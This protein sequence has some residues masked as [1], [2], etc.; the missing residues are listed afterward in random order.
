MAANPYIKVKDSKVLISKHLIKSRNDRGRIP[1]LHWD[2]Y[3]RCFSA[4]VS[5]AVI[6]AVNKEFRAAL[7]MPAR[8]N[9]KV[10]FPYKTEPFHHQKEALAAGFGLPAFAY[11]L[12]P[13]LGKSKVLIDEAQILASRGMLDTVLIVCPK[14]GKGVW[15]TSDELGNWA[16]QIP[17]HGYHDQWSVDVW[18]GVSH[19]NGNSLRW[20]ITNKDALVKATRV[21]ESRQ[22]SDGYK[23]AEA[24]LLSGGNTMLVIDES[25]D[26]ANH[27]S[28][29][30]EAVMRLR[31]LS[32]YRRI[33]TGTFIAD[34]PIDLYSQLYFLDPS[35]V[36][37][38]SFYAFRS[39]FCVMGGYKNKQI[40]AYQNLDELTAM[41][42]SIS[43]K[44]RK[45][46][47]LDLPPKTY[48]VRVIE[49][50]ER[51]KR[52]YNELV[53][54]IG[55][56]ADEH[57][58]TAEMAIT[59]AVKLRQITGGAVLDDEG[60]VVVLGDEKLDETLRLLEQMGRAKCLIWCE[61]THEID[62]L[63]KTIADAGYKVERYDGTI[64]S[65]V[66]RDQ[67]VQRFETGDTQVLVLQNEAGY[68]TLTLNQAEYVII[69]SNS[70][71]LKVRT[72]LEDRCH[73]IGQG[74]NVTYF[75]LIVRGSVDEVVLGSIA[76]KE[77]LA[78][79]VMRDTI[80]PDDPTIRRVIRGKMFRVLP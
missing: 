75:D 71:K 3:Y 57:P 62:R 78:A 5:E 7:T 8:A 33:L 60:N 61:F 28:H 18:R 68:R 43:Y 47:C 48:E 10:V 14:S 29:R 58:I 51:T 39:H 50:S 2:K 36:Y 12:D 55:V 64:N 20:G 76:A 67:I 79:F 41:V 19:H 59:K 21:G 4:Y 34:K 24:F 54:T 31:N 46:E 70:E 9:A 40:I 26:I 80:N 56:W 53:H 65:S 72:Q 42:N 35:I 22:V 1:G 77:N 66:K 74:K 45:D 44:A 73:R 52:V 49:L 16:G 27:A 37:E 15:S 63:C 6:A 30:T 13:G 32:N 23:W 17:T 38:W 69:Y 25:M 11:L